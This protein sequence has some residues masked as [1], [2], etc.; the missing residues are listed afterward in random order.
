MKYKIIKN[1]YPQ[2]DRLLEDIADFL[3]NNGNEVFLRDF[4]EENYEDTSEHYDFLVMIIS[5]GSSENELEMI[6]KGFKIKDSY[7]NDMIL[8]FSENGVFSNMIPF[9]HKLF[10]FEKLEQ[11]DL[12]NF[13]KWCSKFNLFTKKETTKVVSYNILNRI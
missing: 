1:E 12:V 4:D 7:K 9:P 2:T 8:I 6:R 5:S 11:D 3:W 10:H 13:F